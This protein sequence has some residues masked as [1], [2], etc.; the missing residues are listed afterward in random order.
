MNIKI[1]KISKL[2]A[3]ILLNFLLITS[4]LVLFSCGNAPAAVSSVTAPN[5]VTSIESAYPASE[6]V[7]VV[8][9]GNNQP[10]AES[11]AMNALARVFRT[12]VASLTQ[13]SQQFSQIISS[14]ANNRS[15]SFDESQNFS[16]DVNVSTNVHGLIG[17]QID[18]YRSPDN[19]VFVCARMNRRESAARYSGMIRE[20]TA[21]INS[22]LTSA[23]P[24]GTFDA[25]AR[26]SFAHAIA[27]VTDNFQN[28]LEVLDPSAAGR[29]PGY[30]GADAIRTRM[31][32]CASL[33]TIG[34]A[35]NTERPADTTLFTRAAGSFFRDLGFR[36]NEQG[37]G[38]YVLRVN[39]RFEELT[40]SVISCRFFLDAVL[41]NER[42]TA[43]FSFTEDDR[44][45][46]PNNASEARRL[47]VQAVE[48]S[49]KEDK[50]AGEFDSWLNSFIN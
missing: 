48:N 14:S 28:I 5:W 15:I 25:Y 27:K 26:L 41:E 47:A 20:N 24:N 49:F 44:R 7:A 16:Q 46:H 38:N 6:W 36:I 39:V 11:N 8:G 21:I 9:Q 29:R 32:E 10:V 30:G 34:V 43:I 2:R 18:V 4:F 23:V 17:V 50:F 31:V 22:L 1:N 35:V 40:Q 13:S 19:T 3:I 33:I 37:Q 45:A 12:D 42:G